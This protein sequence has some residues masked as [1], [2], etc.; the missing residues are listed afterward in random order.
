M[1]MRPG[2]ILRRGLT[3]PERHPPL[4]SVCSTAEVTMRLSIKQ[5]KSSTYRLGEHGRETKARST[6]PSN[7]L[8]PV[9]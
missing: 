1:C 9:P 3:Y 6:S 2:E 7:Q 5:G 4:C 8:H